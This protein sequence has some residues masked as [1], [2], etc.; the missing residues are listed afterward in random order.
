[1]KTPTIN[2]FKAAGY[3]VDI[4]HRRDHQ[5]AYI[6]PTTKKLLTKVVQQPHYE[7]TKNK[8]GIGEVGL[9]WQLNARGGKT[10]VTVIDPITYESFYAF[11]DCHTDD[12]YDKKVGIER[13]LS[14]IASL[15]MVCDGKE[16][17]KMRLTL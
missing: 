14:R 16:G 2:D 12:N 10:E 3:D 17:F 7:F 6:S 8:H 4:T 15:M 5:I 9:L 1:M 13:C 11:S